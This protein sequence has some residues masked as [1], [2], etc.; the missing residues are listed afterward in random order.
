MDKELG[1]INHILA[2]MNCLLLCTSLLRKFESPPPPP[3]SLKV[4]L[5]FDLK[6]V[7]RGRQESIHLSKHVT[8][9]SKQK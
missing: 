9:I 2:K 1:E 7:L 6:M 5:D 3:S 4:F 8:K